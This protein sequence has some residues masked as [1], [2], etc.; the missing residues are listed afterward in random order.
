MKVEGFGYHQAVFPMKMEGFR[1]H[2]AVSATTTT[3]TA[4]TTTITNTAT[5]TTTSNTAS[6]CSEDSAEGPAAVLIFC[7]RLRHC[8]AACS[9]LHRGAAA[10]C[11]GRN[12]DEDCRLLQKL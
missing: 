10:E 9:R 5:T 8:P 6:Y 4:T 3:N 7:R 2:Q 1:Y 12:M 11:S